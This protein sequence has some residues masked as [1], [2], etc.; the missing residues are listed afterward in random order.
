MN[1]Y[2]EAAERCRSPPAEAGSQGG[3]G[4]KRWGIT[5]RGVSED[6]QRDAPKLHS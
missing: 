2:L 6:R 1:I 4:W 5:A 3:D